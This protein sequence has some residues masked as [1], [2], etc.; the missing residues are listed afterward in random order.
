MESAIKLCVYVIWCVRILFR[1]NHITIHCA[2]AEEDHRRRFPS[3]R[4]RTPL[5]LPVDGLIEQFVYESNVLSYGYGLVNSFCVYV[6]R[7]FTHLCVIS[8]LF[9]HWSCGL[10]LHRRENAVIK[11]NDPECANRVSFESN[12]KYKNIIMHIYGQTVRII[13]KYFK[14]KL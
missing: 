14:L 2:R 6:M 5:M 4:R 11:N 9:T 13:I 1:S 10:L 7:L 12:G 8:G 3:Q